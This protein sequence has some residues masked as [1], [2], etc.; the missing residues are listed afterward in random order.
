MTRIYLISLH[1]INQQV[2]IDPIQLIVFLPGLF[3]GLLGGIMYRHYY[4]KYIKTPYARNMN[5]REI[6]SVI[7]DGEGLVLTLSESE[8]YMENYIERNVLVLENQIM[9]KPTITSLATV[10]DEVAGYIQNTES[11]VAKYLK[12]GSRMFVIVISSLSY[13]LVLLSIIFRITDLYYFSIL[14]QGACLTIAFIMSFVEFDRALRSM[15][16]GVK[17][18]L[19]D[20][21]ERK[22][23]GNILRFRFLIYFELT[24]LTVLK[25]MYYIL[26]TFKKRK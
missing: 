3:L 22:Q 24:V 5:G 6:C 25:L 17:Y 12:E 14:L 19:V 1:I 23:V 10:L 4:A 16:I 2:E 11:T 21:S 26:D 8:K 18:S 9:N 15:E 7:V 13:G 20:D